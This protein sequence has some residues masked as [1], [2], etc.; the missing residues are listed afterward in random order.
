VVFNSEDID[1]WKNQT[2]N[3]LLSERRAILEVIQEAYVIPAMLDNAIQGEVE[4]Y[5]KNYNALNLII[6]ALDRN[7][8]DRVSYLE[9][10]YEIWL[11]LYM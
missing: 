7:V 2:R 3:Y 10:T 4:K 8:Y 9:T 5:E 1:Y 6:T 11:K